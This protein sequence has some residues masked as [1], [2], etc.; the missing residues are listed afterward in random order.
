[1]PDLFTS[2]L[3]ILIRVF[4]VVLMLVGGALFAFSA[5]VMAAL[6]RVPAGEGVRVM[7]QI[8]K[9]VFTPWFMVPFFLTLPLGLGAIVVALL[10]TDR[11][12][13]PVL[14]IAGVLSSAGVFV[15]TAAGNVPLNNRLERVDADSPELTPEARELWQHYLR[16]WTRLN[17]VRVIASVAGVVCLA[18]TLRLLA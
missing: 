18:E 1:M 10:H 9:T 11:P 12:W 16:V 7:Q 5:F 6:A 3:P 4:I 8:N 15:V 13:W 17:H 2:L 14:L